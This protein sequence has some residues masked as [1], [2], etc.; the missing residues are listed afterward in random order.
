[1]WIPEGSTTAVIAKAHEPETMA[2]GGIA[3]TMYRLRESYDLPKTT[4][5]VRNYIPDYVVCKET[6]TANQGM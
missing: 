6:K 2:H 5:H 1:M 4:V 3:K